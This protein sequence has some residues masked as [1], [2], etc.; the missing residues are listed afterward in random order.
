MLYRSQKLLILIIEY[1]TLEYCVGFWERRRKSSGREWRRWGTGMCIRSGSLR[2]WHVPSLPSALTGSTFSRY[3][4]FPLLN[5]IFTQPGSWFD[6]DFNNQL[7]EREWVVMSF[8]P[9]LLWGLSVCENNGLFYLIGYLSF[10][11][12]KLVLC[13]RYLEEHW[14]VFCSS[15]LSSRLCIIFFA[16]FKKTSCRVTELSLH[17]QTWH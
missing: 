2:T 6:D 12:W 15:Q 7:I 16:L 3:P 17:F 1:F 8:D 5:E 9:T 13:Y 11:L 14:V 10:L 4:F